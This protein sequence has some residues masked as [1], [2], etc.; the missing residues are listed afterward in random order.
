MLSI[1]IGNLLRN[2]F[3]YTDEGQVVVEIGERQ[4][5]HP[6]HRRRHPGDQDRGDVPPFVRGE[7]RHRGG[8]G[9]GLTIVR[10]LSDRFGWPISVESTPGVG[11]TVVI[12]FPTARL[13]IKKRGFTLRRHFLHTIFTPPAGR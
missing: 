13:A 10:R 9:V 12:N 11:T 1:L 4:V 6:R 5:T 3:S 2:A 8:H 7:G